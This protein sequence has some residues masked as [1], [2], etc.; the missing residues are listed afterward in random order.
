MLAERQA[1]TVGKLSQSTSLKPTQSRPAANRFQRGDGVST[2]LWVVVLLLSS[3]LWSSSAVS[4]AQSIGCSAFSSTVA[5]CVQPGSRLGDET[6]GRRVLPVLTAEHNAIPGDSGLSENSNDAYI[7]AGTGNNSDQRF[8]WGRALLESFEL[9]SIEQ[10]YVVHDDWKWVGGSSSE[11]GIPFNHYWRDY[12]QSL[13]A[14]V[15][16]GWNDGD[17]NMYGYVGHP[18]Q[19]VATSYI[20][21]QND[22][23]YDKVEFSK[24]KEY[25]HSR[26]E[27]TI[28]NAVYSTQWNLGPISEPT[29]EKYGTLWRDPWNRGNSQWRY[30]G[31]GQI[32][33]VM[34]PVGGFGWLVGIDFLD[35][36]VTRRVEGA[37]A[38]RFLVNATRCALDPIMIGTNLL[39]GKRPWYRASR[40][41]RDVYYANHL[42]GFQQTSSGGGTADSH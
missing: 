6:S 31:M 28:F 38:N 36:F 33:L 42:K 18:I 2:S 40:D 15:H 41:A 10:A 29:V 39:H 8:H 20:F 25:W 13:D 17:P 9:L 14:W 12:K 4:A 22:P 3:L 19:G 32:D 35:R 16:S 34:T 1:D 23:K 7:S 26:I 30:T 37:T 11:N 21:L 24:T 5:D 27:A